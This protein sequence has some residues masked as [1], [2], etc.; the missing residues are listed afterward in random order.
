M[1]IDV[2]LIAFLHNFTHIKDLVRC[3]FILPEPTIH[4]DTLWICLQISFYGYC[5]RWRLRFWKPCSV[6]WCLGICCSQSCHPFCELNRTDH[7]AW[8]FP[9]WVGY[10]HHHSFNSFASIFQQ[11]SCY[12]VVSG[13]SVIQL[14]FGEIC[15]VH[16]LEHWRFV[17]QNRAPR[18]FSHHKGVLF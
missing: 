4:I 11:L 16:V 17:E 2:V 6:A 9:D 14:L 15:V 7:T 12:V 18:D 3:A 8:H 5:S 13:C 1:E 10:F